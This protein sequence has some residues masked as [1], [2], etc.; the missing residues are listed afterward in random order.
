MD[1]HLTRALKKL[2][3]YFSVNKVEKLSW[4]QQYFSALCQQRYSEAPA[5]AGFQLG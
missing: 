2:F 3:S 4:I 5:S 1:L